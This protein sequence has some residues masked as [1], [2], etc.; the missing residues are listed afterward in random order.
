LRL[1]SQQIAGRDL[2]NE[3]WASADVSA[4]SRKSWPIAGWELAELP[5]A[6]SGDAVE[7]VRDVVQRLA[8][9]DPDG[10]ASPV[11]IGLNGGP[12]VVTPTLL[13]AFDG[14]HR[15]ARARDLIAQFGELQVMD[16]DW[17]SMPGSYRIRVNTSNGFR[18][19]DIAA[20]LASR[21]GVS[22]AEPDWIFTGGG[23]HT[24][25]DQYYGFQWALNNTG[26]NGGV[27]DMDMNV[28][29]AWD[30]TFGDAQ[31]KVLIID[32]GVQQDH[33]DLQQ[34]PGVDVTSDGPG[35]GGPVNAWD[36]HGTPVAGCV[37]AS[38]DNWIG[39]A[40]IAPACKSVSARTMISTGSTGAW[41]SQVSWTVDALAYAE[42]AGVRVTNNS[43]SYGFVS[44]AI[45]AKYLATRDAGMVHF[46]SIG[47][48]ATASANYPSSL[49]TVISVG[50]VTRS[51]V[52]SPFSSSGPD[53][54]LVAPGSDIATTDRT[55]AAGYFNSDYIYMYGTSFSSPYCAG[56]ASLVLSIN[57]TL[58]ASEVEAMLKSTAR[59]L[60]A[61]GVD[62][63][64]GWGLIDAHAAV[65]EAADGLG[66]VVSWGVGGGIVNAPTGA[67]LVQVAGGSSHALALRADGSLVAWGDDSE[68]Q[69]SN[70]PA[71]T[72]FTQVAASRRFSMALRVDGSIASWG[73]DQYGQVSQTPTEADFVQV[74]TNGFGVCLGLRSDGSIIGWGQAP[75]TP[76]ETGFTQVAAGHHHGA[77]LRSDGSIVSWGN[78]VEGQVSNT[79]TGTGFTQVAA[80]FRHSLALRSDGSIVSWGR[81]QGPFA[82]SGGGIVSNT[83]TETGFI[84]VAAGDYHSLALRS[85]GSIVS[86]GVDRD[87]LGNVTGQVSNTPTG[88]GFT[89]V[90]GGWSYSLAL[91]EAQD[92][93]GNAYC[94]GD[95]SGAACP[96]GAVGNPGEGC[97]NT[98]GTGAKLVGT[99]D[100]DLGQ[101]TFTLTVSGAPPNKPGLFFQGTTQ[102]ANPLGDGI[103]CSNA[104]LRYG[105]N[106]TDGQGN[107]VQAGLGENA[108]AGE[109]L[110]YQFWFRDPGNSCGG[111]FN[112]SN[113]W[114]VTWE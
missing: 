35:P 91:G 56:L 7:Q 18:V 76:A 53:L 107:A 81:D 110:N 89:Q 36:N 55:G 106:M 47:N 37:S 31:Q 79:P 16:E 105:V 103:W 49:P 75:T 42:S 73:W 40:G 63:T 100:A 15:G 98:S 3:S 112:F 59:D 23:N 109:V 90:E 74:A 28:A 66:A 83:P 69:V 64:F 11:F 57:P 86:W 80:G 111:G 113:A 67:D 62:N 9:Q 104:D 29:E 54:D 24:P 94:F 52:L 26:Q 78:D 45:E 27:P 5:V 51:G 84:Q 60:G 92:N 38:I 10:F 1:S 88:T 58:S 39:V 96:C 65:Q 99:G 14:L 34:V 71:G 48:S 19:L 20:E 21:D 95:G 82:D 102:I 12:V 4:T 17:A 61:T 85:D 44:A 25:N 2:S 50:S 68:G 108:S 97:M 114:T 93:T 13:V 101:E 6:L 33:P 70:T 43:N 77:A 8:A 22:Y 30:I 41:I 72:D 32:S 87:F 46:A